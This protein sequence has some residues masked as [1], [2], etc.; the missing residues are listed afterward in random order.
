MK[1]EICNSGLLPKHLHYQHLSLP[2][3][4]TMEEGGASN[5]V[6]EVHDQSHQ[7]VPMHMPM[8]APQW[9]IDILQ[10]DSQFLQMWQQHQHSWEQKAHQAMS[11][12]QNMVK[13]GGQWLQVNHVIMHQQITEQH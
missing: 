7:L 13:N 11:Q 9:T 2:P 8:V 4:D 1:M 10:P 3:E 12:L 6:P 5:A